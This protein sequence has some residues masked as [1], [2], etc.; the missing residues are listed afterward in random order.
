MRLVRCSQTSSWYQ[1]ERLCLGPCSEP[2]ELSESAVQLDFKGLMM[3]LKHKG[4]SKHTF[5]RFFE[6][7]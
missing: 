6:G 7:V 2:E 4:L 1:S 3:N 5:G